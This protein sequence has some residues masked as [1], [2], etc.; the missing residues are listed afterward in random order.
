MPC[1][2]EHQIQ[3]REVCQHPEDQPRP[4]PR[5]GRR[6]QSASSAQGYSFAWGKT[7]EGKE[8]EAPG[9]TIREVTGLGCQRWALNA[10]HGRGWRT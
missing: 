10:G 3:Q 2:R 1:R 4:Q 5:G 8:T 9:G 7:T 6:S